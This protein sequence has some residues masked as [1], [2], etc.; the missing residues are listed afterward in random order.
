[1]VITVDSAINE[2]SLA[3]GG[4]DCKEDIRDRVRLRPAEPERTWMRR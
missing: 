1:L 3:V 2:N 4:S